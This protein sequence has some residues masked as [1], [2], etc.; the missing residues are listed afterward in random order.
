MCVG[1]QRR[2]SPSMYSSNHCLEELF[3]YPSLFFI[4]HLR[5]LTIRRTC[6]SFRFLRGSL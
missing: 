6:G 3:C 1:I 5:N 2:H 4:T